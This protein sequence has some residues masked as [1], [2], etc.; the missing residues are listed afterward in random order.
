MKKLLSIILAAAMA[1]SLMC[2]S[3]NAA[4]IDQSEPQTDLPEISDSSE[5]TESDSEDKTD[6]VTEPVAGTDEESDAGT[7]QEPIAD[8]QG[9]DAE[10]EQENAGELTTSEE[11]APP[12]S[13]ATTED[14]SVSVTNGQCGDAEHP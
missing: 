4:E 14:N 11:I 7:E 1:L 10:A 12:T 5:P 3:L 13:M 9:S 6:A 8:E 2:S